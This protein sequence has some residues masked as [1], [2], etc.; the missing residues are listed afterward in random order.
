MKTALRTALAVGALFCLAAAIGHALILQFQPD[1]ALPLSDALEGIF[2][3]GLMGFGVVF[4][5][6][7]P[8]RAAGIFAGAGLLLAFFY[9]LVPSRAAAEDYW[10]ARKT[11]TGSTSLQ[12]CYAIQGTKFAL[13]VS[14]NS[15]CEFGFLPTD[16][17]VAVT[18][19][20]GGTLQ[21][22]G[23]TTVPIPATSASG[24][25]FHDQF[26]AG[27]VSFKHGDQCIACIAADGGAIT[28]DLYRTGP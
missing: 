2:F 9:A 19:S 6:H 8:V 21:A 28:M 22:V 16:G 18:T 7:A 25:L 26:I 13:G 17:G 14:G 4:V 15:L 12:Y 11:T 5:T 27:G 20:D 10:V 1:Y 3:C 23:S 24:P